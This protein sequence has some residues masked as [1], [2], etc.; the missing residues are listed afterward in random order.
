MDFFPLFCTARRLMNSPS[1]SFC[2]CGW[3]WI[4]HGISTKKASFDQKT[5]SSARLRCVSDMKKKLDRTGIRN[6]S[7]DS[8]FFSEREVS[9]CVLGVSVTFW[10]GARTEGGQPGPWC[11]LGSWALHNTRPPLLYAPSFLPSLRPF[12]VPEVPDFYFTDK[13]RGGG[14]GRQ[15]EIQV[16]AVIKCCLET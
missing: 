6:K 14:K 7:R 16:I 5:M 8:R 1:I 3:D 2:C 13:K 9:L 11:A 10:K 4:S 12:V 15:R